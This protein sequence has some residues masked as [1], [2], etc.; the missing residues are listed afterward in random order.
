MVG[1]GYI[2]MELGMAFAK[3]GASVTV[4]EALPKILPLYDEELTLPVARRAADLGI[5]VHARGAGAGHDKGGLRV[6]DANGAE[7]KVPPTRF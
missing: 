4:V 3:L 1:A 2:G 7:T 5:D 6:E